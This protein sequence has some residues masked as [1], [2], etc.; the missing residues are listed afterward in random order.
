MFEKN[1]KCKHFF[2]VAWLPVIGILSFAAGT[3]MTQDLPSTHPVSPDL[4]RITLEQVK[5]SADPVA[6]PLARL[7]QLSV[8]AARQHRLGVQA[9][10]FPKG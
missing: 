4:R 1:K 8:E 3:G 2:G 7:G 6:M 10:Y 9:D 5:Q